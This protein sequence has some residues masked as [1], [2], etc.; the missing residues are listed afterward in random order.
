M[1]A[2]QA[3]NEATRARRRAELQAEE[4]RQ[5]ESLGQINRAVL[6]RPLLMDSAYE[7]RASAA[8][9]LLDVISLRG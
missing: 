4:N 2:A 9:W 8:Q 1:Q 6:T 3:N 7:Y 5:W